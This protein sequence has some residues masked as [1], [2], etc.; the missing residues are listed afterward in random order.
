MKCAVILVDFR[1]LF[2]SD[3][4]MCTV[5]TCVIDFFLP[6]ISFGMGIH[7][8]NVFQF[9][10]LFGSVVCLKKEILSLDVDYSVQKT[11]S[12]EFIRWHNGN[13]ISY[14]SMHIWCLQIYRKFSWISRIHVLRWWTWY[15]FYTLMKNVLHTLFYMIFLF[16][17]FNF[18]QYC[19]FGTFHHFW[20]LMHEK[21]VNI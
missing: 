6:L 18:L 8:W 14:S 13:A 3:R 19:T 20:Y 16:Q 9:I 1:L 21:W 4:C 10:Y 7:R 15:E 12:I 5:Y 2:I 17:S 11:Y